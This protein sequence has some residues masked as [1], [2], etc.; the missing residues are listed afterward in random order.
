[1]RI[2]F[3]GGG[4][5]G[6]IYP[7][8][9]VAD[10][11][12]KAMPD[13]EIL[14]AG[15][16]F[17]MEA[18]IVPQAGYNFTPIKVHG[19]Q[20]KITPENIVKN[21]QACFYLATSLPQARRIIKDF[22][23]DIVFGT[24]GYVCGPILRA[25]AKMGIK[26][27]VHESNAYPGMTTRLLSKLVNVV[28]L[29]NETA[30]KHLDEGV[31]CVITGNPLR[32]QISQKSRES[33]RIEL[34]LDGGMTILSYGGSLGAGGI[35][36]AMLDLMVWEQKKGDIN[37]IHGYGG[38]GKDSFIPDLRARGVQIKG[39]KRLDVREYID[40]IGVCMAAAD[41]VISRAGAMTLAEI[42]AVGRAS[43][44]IP[45]PIVAENHQ[46]HNALVLENKGAAIVVEQKNLTSQKIIEIVE[47]LYNNR[48]KLTQMSQNAKSMAVTDALTNI[49]GV[50]MNL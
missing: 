9:A 35:N 26:T 3:V 30:R 44:L 37:H 49:L 17:G 19:F 42:Q 24:G 7:A 10:A 12:K 23:P 45:S 47:E 38:M 36:D 20:R 11:V 39:N 2:L 5:G 21:V 43:I 1:M 48:E 29:P 40:N 4:T 33:A 27:A 14:F 25:A 18:R 31:N 16:P 46:Y 50:L 8:L 15:T 32:G 13:C 28:M 41:L 6:H 34:K 22:K